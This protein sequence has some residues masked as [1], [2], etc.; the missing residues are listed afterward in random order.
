MKKIDA[1][2]FARAVIEEGTG[3]MFAFICFQ[4]D[5][6]EMQFLQKLMEETL[7][8]EH[9]FCGHSYEILFSD[10]LKDEK[11]CAVCSCDKL[12]NASISQM[13]MM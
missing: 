13:T 12:L 6:E 10:F 7:F 3:H 2:L 9:T 4:K 11:E 1:G 5:G 8:I